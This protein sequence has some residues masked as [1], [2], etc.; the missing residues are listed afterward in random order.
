M[1]NWQNDDNDSGNDFDDADG[2][3]DDVEDDDESEPTVSCP[4]CDREIHE[5]AQRCPH[6]GQ[7][8]SSEDGPSGRKPWWI[9]AG[10]L[11]CLAMVVGWLFG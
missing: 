8:I 3:D 5:D 6:C 1:A 10:V 11:L 7:Y 4:W 2:F 9:V